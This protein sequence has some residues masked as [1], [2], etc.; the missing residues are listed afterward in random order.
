MYIW[1]ECRSSTI[2]LRCSISTDEHF[3]LNDV[4]SAHTHTPVI[5]V[6]V[7]FTKFPEHEL[8]IELPFAESH[9][10]AY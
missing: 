9:A 2:E 10:N 8:C 5:S 1:Q 3:S 6:C 7:Q 4:Q